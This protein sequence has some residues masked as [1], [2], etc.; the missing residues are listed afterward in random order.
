MSRIR[1]YQTTSRENGYSRKTMPESISRG[2]L[3]VHWMS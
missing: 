1:M 3:Y 2:R